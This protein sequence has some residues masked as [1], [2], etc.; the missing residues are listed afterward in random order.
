MLA[1]TKGK[2]DM[3]LRYGNYNSLYFTTC[4]REIDGGTLQN[5]FIYSI[6]LKANISDYI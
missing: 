5:N 4:V 3:Y 6:E 1:S 2:Y